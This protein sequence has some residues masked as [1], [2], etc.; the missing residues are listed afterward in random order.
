MGAFVILNVKLW[1]S[2]VR[3]TC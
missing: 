2:L 3:F 1:L